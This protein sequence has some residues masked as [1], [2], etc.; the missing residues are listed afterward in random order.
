MT[1]INETRHTAVDGTELYA[2][3]SDGLCD[4]C[5][6]FKDAATG[7]PEQLTCPDSGPC[8]PKQRADR[9]FIIWVKPHE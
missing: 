4:G 5:Y 9:A 7:W 3:T 6:Y 8:V 1:P 2:Q